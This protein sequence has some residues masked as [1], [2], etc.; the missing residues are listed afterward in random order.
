MCGLLLGAN[1]Q[2]AP[3]VE[4]TFALQQRKTPEEVVPAVTSTGCYRGLSTERGVQSRR[5]WSGL[6]LGT[7]RNSPA[8]EQLLCTGER[9]WVCYVDSLRVTSLSWRQ[10]QGVMWGP[11]GAEVRGAD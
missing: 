3:R 10:E 6:F 8:G 7:H 4:E 1:L 11:F 5:H 9:K 2:R